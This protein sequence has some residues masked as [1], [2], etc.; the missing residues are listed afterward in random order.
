MHNGEF[1]GATTYIAVLDSHVRNH[2]EKNSSPSRFSWER[3]LKIDYESWA[4]MIVM[5]AP[6]STK[7][8]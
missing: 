1:V 6:G 7:F 2:T 4:V 8:W 3:Q 5:I